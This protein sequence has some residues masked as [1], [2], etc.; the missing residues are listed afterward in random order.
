MPRLA[1]CPP[2][3]EE[4]SGSVGSGRRSRVCRGRRLFVLP[5]E[6]Y[7]ADLSEWGLVA[8]TGL[9]GWRDYGGLIAAK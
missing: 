6:G 8:R 2:Q 1:L 5:A 4:E 7:L 9:R 3:T